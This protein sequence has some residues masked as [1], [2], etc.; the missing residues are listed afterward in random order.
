MIAGLCPAPA[1]LSNSYTLKIFTTPDNVTFPGNDFALDCISFREC[2]PPPSCT[3][4]PNAFDNMSYKPNSGPNVPISCSEVAIWQCLLPVFNLSGNFLCQGD[5][6]DPQPPVSWTLTHPNSGQVDQG[7]S[8]GPGFGVSIPSA[9]F[10]LPGLYTLTLVGI[11]GEDTCYCEI[12]IETPGCGSN[13]TADFSA[14]KVDC[15]KYNFFA[16]ANGTAPFACCWDFDGNPA[17]CESTQ[18]NPM[19]QFPTCGTYMV[20]LTVTDAANCSAT[21]CQAVS[22][23]DIVPPVAVCN[24]GVGVNLDA[25]CMFQVTTAFVDAGSFDDCRIQSMTVSPSVLT[26]C[27]NHTVTLTVT[28]WCGNTSTCTI[29]IQTLEVVPPTITCPQSLTVQGVLDALGICKTEVTGI[30]PASV[31]DNCGLLGVGYTINAGSLVA[32]P[33][34][35]G[36]TFNQGTTTV[37]YYASDNCLNTASCSFTVTVVC[38]DCECP[39]PGVEGIELVTNG[40]FNNSGGFVSGYSN[41]CS[42]Q[43][44]GQFCITNDASIVNPG[45]SN[46]ADPSGSGNI[47]VANGALT[48]NTDVL[49]YSFNS[50][51]PNTNYIFSFYHASV[52]GASPAQL[53]VHFGTT[54]AGSIAQLALNT[55]AWRK[56]CVVWNSG[57]NTATAV[58]I[59]NL[60][61]QAQGNDFAIDKVRFRECRKCTPLPAD[62]VLWMPMD[63]TGGENAIQSIVG[64]LAAIPNGSIGLSGLTPAPGKVDALS[65]GAGALGFFGPPASPVF[66]SNDPKLNF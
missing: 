66:V 11:C 16:F 61:S 9:S 64:G 49:C 56:Y 41:N 32:L 19:W 38:P 25:N 28:D 33:D 29:G 60:N 21:Y 55:C 20:C 44:E 36:I 13:C 37:A 59:R 6:C 14:D 4:P 24:P 10:S 47:F 45:F 54:Q 43:T 62:A 27:A 57:N 34:A 17:T 31:F 23:T 3:C 8:S 7:S 63:E 2:V 30:G 1:N 26:G 48:P 58:C 39:T 51:K 50:L 22:V 12:L 40:D 18:Q 35:S 15:D 53:A 42:G 46:C 65:S 52:S 5:N